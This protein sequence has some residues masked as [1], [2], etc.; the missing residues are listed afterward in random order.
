MVQ[1]NWNDMN[2]PRWDSREISCHQNFYPFVASPSI[3]SPL[4]PPYL[5]LC[6]SSPSPCLRENT[7]FKGP[8]HLRPHQ[9]CYYSRTAVACYDFFCP[10]C[11]VYPPL[12][13]HVFSPMSPHPH[14]FTSPLQSLVLPMPSIRKRR[15]FTGPLHLPS[16]SVLLLLW[17]SCRRLR[18]FYA[19]FTTLSHILNRDLYLTHSTF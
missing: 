2:N 16:S 11:I 3:S 8:I 10:F 4:P 18:L 12:P 7:Y 14:P 17:N 6:P 19:R 5:H 13:S 9:C 15:Y 1:S